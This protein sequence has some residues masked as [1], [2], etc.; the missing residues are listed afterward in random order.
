MKITARQFSMFVDEYARWGITT[1][2]FR[3]EQHSWVSRRDEG[4]SMHRMSPAFDVAETIDRCIQMA[5]EASFTAI[6]VEV[7]A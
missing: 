1:N 3:G 7:E 6:G 5:V 2:M 4:D